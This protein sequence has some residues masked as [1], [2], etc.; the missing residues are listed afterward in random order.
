MDQKEGGVFFRE[1]KKK[2]P[3]F[4]PAHLTFNVWE[5]AVCSGAIYSPFFL[6]IFFFQ[7][8]LWGNFEL[9]LEEVMYQTEKGGG[10]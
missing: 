4:S 7:S 9:Y 8:V 5:N 3:F 6:F 1:I 10:E 2:G